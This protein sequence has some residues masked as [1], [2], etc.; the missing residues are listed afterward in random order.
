MGEKLS[1]NKGRFTAGERQLKKKKEKKKEGDRRTDS[2]ACRKGGPGFDFGRQL[3]TATKQL[4]S[5]HGP[6][7]IKP[8]KKNVCFLVP[9]GLLD[10]E[11][12]RFGANV[13]VGYKEGC[14]GQFSTKDVE[15][16]KVETKKIPILQRQM[17]LKAHVQQSPVIV[18]LSNTN[19]TRLQLKKMIKTTNGSRLLTL[20]GR[21]A[22][23]VVLRVKSL[24]IHWKAKAFDATS[25][26]VFIFSHAIHQKSSVC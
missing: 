12:N 24:E 26:L 21:L 15:Q 18:C 14:E 19:T 5:R 20:A 17:S 2:G 8:H 7:N 11:Q 3:V 23:I 13:L 6:R 1:L 10:D 16:H 25:N 9:I 22:S 4:R